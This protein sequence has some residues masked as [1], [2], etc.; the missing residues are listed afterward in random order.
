MA[1]G[2][3]VVYTGNITTKTANIQTAKC[4]FNSIVSS[5]KGRFMTLDL[6]DF[7]LCS[8]LPG[9]E[10]IRIPTHLLPPAIIELYQVQNKIANGYVYAEVRKGM[11]GLPQTGKLAN[12]WLHKFLAPFGYALPRNPQL[13]ETS[14]Q[15]PDAHPCC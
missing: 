7:T 8:D 15:Q 14:P 12:G 10:C 11:Y 5:P 2:N 6:K 9:Y 1:G 3:K 4:L 13:M